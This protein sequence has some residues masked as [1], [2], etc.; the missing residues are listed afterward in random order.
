MDHLISGARYSDYIPDSAY[1]RKEDIE[2]NMI[3]CPECK[4][5]GK[6]YYSD[7]CGSE[8]IDGICQNIECFESCETVSE[9]CDECNGE[10]EVEE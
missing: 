6:I 5:H 2:I 9:K 10:G 3:E 1:D 7:C 8:V 4:G